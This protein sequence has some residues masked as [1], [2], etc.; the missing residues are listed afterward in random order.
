M[1]IVPMKASA[2]L[3]AIHIMTCLWFSKDI[4]DI[5]KCPAKRFSVERESIYI[6]STI[7][8]INF[9]PIKEFV[10]TLFKRQGR[11]VLVV[12]FFRL[13]VNTD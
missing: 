1:T 10:K 4:P 13:N 7:K 9:I 11:H 3:Y 12:I 6:F 2:K 8:D 5:M